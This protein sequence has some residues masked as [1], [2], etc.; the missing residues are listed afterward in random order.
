MHL[1]TTFHSHSLFFSSPH[2]SHPPC[3]YFAPPKRFKVLQFT[4]NGK[5]SI[6]LSASQCQFRICNSL[7]SP[8]YRYHFPHPSV[9]GRSILLYVSFHCCSPFQYLHLFQQMS[10]ASHAFLRLLLKCSVLYDWL[11][12]IGFHYHSLHHFQLRSSIAHP[13]LRKILPQS[14]F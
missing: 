4:N 5:S 12:D 9:G 14:S 2:L 7:E 11:T 13:Q 6:S 10:P 3:Q 8:L 1:P